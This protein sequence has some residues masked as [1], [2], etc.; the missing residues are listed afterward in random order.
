MFARLV[1]GAFSVSVHEQMQQDERCCVNAGGEAGKLLPTYVFSAA[2]VLV[3]FH[4]FTLRV[5][6]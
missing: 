4:V 2:F 3:S 1:L 5:C 6:V